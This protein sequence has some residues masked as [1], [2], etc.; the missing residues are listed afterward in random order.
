MQPDVLIIGGAAT[1][2]SVAFHLAA[3][4]AFR[5][6]VLVLE[7]DPSYR[8]CAS[9]L[10]AASIRQ[11][12]STGINIHISKFGVDFLRQVAGSEDDGG[13][14]LA[15]VGGSFEMPLDAAAVRWPGNAEGLPVPT[16]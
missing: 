7:K 1:G 2:S 16:G 8:F 15:E 9:A 4:P 14:P 10:S 3:D 6:R 5:G 13:F 12:F 11:Q